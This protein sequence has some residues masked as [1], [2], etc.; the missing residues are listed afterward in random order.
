[1]NL[2]DTELRVRESVTLEPGSRLFLLDLNATK[3]KLPCVLASAC[4]TLPTKTNKN[5]LTLTVE[6]V[7]NTSAV[8][9]IAAPKPPHAVTLE[10]KVLETFYYSAADKLLWVRF[11]N[12]PRP[13]ELAVRF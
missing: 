13:R 10:D 12:E 2:F 1:M 7:G 6:G 11:S 8:V 5:A 4:K 3:G 9:L